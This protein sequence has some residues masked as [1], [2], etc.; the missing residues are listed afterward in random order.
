M[1]AHEQHRTRTL[2]LTGV[3]HAFTHLYQVALMPLYLLIQ[4]DFGFASVGQAT[5]LLTV[6]LAACFA[7]SYPIGVLADKHSRK[8]LLCLGLILNGLGFVA[9]ALAP[10]YGLAL[11]AVGLI[12]DMLEADHGSLLGWTGRLAQYLGSVY[13]L[14]AAV[15]A[16]RAGGDGRP[17]AGGAGGLQMGQARGPDPQERGGVA[18][19]E[20]AAAAGAT[21]GADA[22]GG[23][24][25][26]GNKPAPITF[27][28]NIGKGQPIF[29]FISLKPIS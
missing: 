29:R 3:L 7:P 4:K 25:G 14:V 24:P 19:A 6:M 8:R 21:A 20:G 13:L 5:L 11:L 1:D 18:G 16:A 2:W 9:L 23:I 17:V 27:F 15:A 22:P 26:L 10:N 28:V 12:G